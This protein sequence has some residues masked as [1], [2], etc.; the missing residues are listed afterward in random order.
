MKYRL[1]FILIALICFSAFSKE[2]C[3]VSFQ[4]E[5]GEKTKILLQENEGII[6]C[7]GDRFGMFKSFQKICMMKTSII[8]GLYYFGLETTV[9]DWGTDAACERGIN[10][11]INLG[12]IPQP[13]QYP[14]LSF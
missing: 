5:N 13:T 7:R 12:M 9:V 3:I 2:G 11:N 14:Y 6:Y 4:N 10:P 8:N 1:I